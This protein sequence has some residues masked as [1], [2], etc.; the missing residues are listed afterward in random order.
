M[1]GALILVATEVPAAP[2]VGVMTLGVVVALVGHVARSYRVVGIGIAILF[3]ATAAMVV[4]AYVS[5]HGDET[6]PRP[7]K[8]PGQAGF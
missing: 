5:Y 7:V 1:P 6:D 8:P 3:L 4:G 2:V